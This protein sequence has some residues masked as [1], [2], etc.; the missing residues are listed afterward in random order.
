MIR[1]IH[2]I[3]FII[4]KT[5]LVPIGHPLDDKTAAVTPE[6]ART[7]PIDKSKPPQIKIIV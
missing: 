5:K 4:P 7:L 2:L 6:K 1:R 3:V